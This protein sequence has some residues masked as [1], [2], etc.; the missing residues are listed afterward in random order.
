MPSAEGPQGIF[1]SCVVPQ[2]RQGQE[3]DAADAGCIGKSADAAGAVQFV[4]QLAVEG[5]T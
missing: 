4:P 3:A 1:R 2:A 5:S